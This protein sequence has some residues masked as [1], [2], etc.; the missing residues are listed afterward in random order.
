MLPYFLNAE[1]KYDPK[2]YNQVSNADKESLKNNIAKQLV[3]QRFS[4]DTF[5]SSE[6]LGDYTFYGIKSSEKE[7]AFLASINQEKRSFDTVS[8]DKSSYPESEVKKSHQRTS[9]FSTLTASQ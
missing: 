2:I 5:G 8:F 9:L 6:M 3:W 7:T 1:G 4:D